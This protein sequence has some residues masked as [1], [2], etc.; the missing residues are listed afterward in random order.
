MDLKDLD[1]KELE[2]LLRLAWCKETAAPGCQATWTEVNPSWG[3]CAATALIV[4]DIFHGD[5][6]RCVV[7][8]YGSHYYN[9]L[10][11][12]LVVDF[13]RE[14]FPGNTEHFEGVVTSRENILHSDRAK[15]AKTEERYLLLKADIMY[16]HISSGYR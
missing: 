10:P 6:V 14:Q 5:I 16:L 15:Y 8:P 4:Q 11:D 2:N 9:I 7:E 13:T 3:Q 12:R 1:L